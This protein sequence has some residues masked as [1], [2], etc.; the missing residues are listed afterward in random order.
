MFEVTYDRSPLQ[1]VDAK[2]AP[3]A[4]KLEARMVAKTAFIIGT[5][6]CGTTMLAQMLNSHSKICVPFELQLLFEYSKN[7]ARLHEVFKDNK[8]EN[9]GAKDFIDLIESRTP[10]R[11]H[12]YFDYRRFFETQRYPIRSLNE[13]ANRLFSEIAESKHKTIFIEQTPWYG[14]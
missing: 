14:Q 8:N 11:F 7:G 6:R 13:L 10:H 4:E 3:G 1:A 2:T 5:G 9:F 12:E